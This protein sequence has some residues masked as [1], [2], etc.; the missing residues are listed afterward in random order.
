[1]S[2]LDRYAAKNEN[3]VPVVNPHNGLGARSAPRQHRELAKGQT[4]RYQ[5]PSPWLVR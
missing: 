5:G 3:L 2:R 1:M 4:Q